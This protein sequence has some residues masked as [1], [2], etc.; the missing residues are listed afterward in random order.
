VI[1]VAQIGRVVRIKNESPEESQAGW[2]EPHRR[3][4]MPNLRCLALDSAHMVVNLIGVIET[5]NGAVGSV[6]TP[7][8]ASVIQKDG[9]ARFG[10]P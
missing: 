5:R 10:R 2:Y 4:A 8:T 3:C 9:A 7:P 1:R 6:V